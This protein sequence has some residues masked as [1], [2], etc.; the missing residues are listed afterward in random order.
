[1]CKDWKHFFPFWYWGPPQ[2]SVRG[3]IRSPLLEGISSYFLHIFFTF[4]S[5]FFI[6]P[7]Y[8]FISLHNS[9]IFS[10]YFFIFSSYFFHNSLIF[11]S[12]FLIIPSYFYIFPSNFFI[13]RAPPPYI[14]ALGLGKIP[15]S[16]GFIGSE[17]SPVLHTSSIFPAYFFIFSSYFLHTSS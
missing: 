13:F 9:F 3:R 4:P 12:C 14:W 10:L 17:L 6:F 5:Y 8:F 15:R 2:E 16:G 1:M 11:S 7:S